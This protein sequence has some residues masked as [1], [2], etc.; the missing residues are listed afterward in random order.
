MRGETLLATAAAIVFRLP[1]GIIA[2]MA[3]GSSLRMVRRT[4][5]GVAWIVNV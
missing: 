4:V 2:T 3:Q 5:Q 1:D